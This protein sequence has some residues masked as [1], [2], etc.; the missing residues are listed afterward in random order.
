VRDCVT[1][2]SHSDFCK[3]NF[4]VSSDI[5]A[6]AICTDA[7]PN[8]KVENIHDLEIRPIKHAPFDSLRISSV[9]NLEEPER[10]DDAARSKYAAHQSTKDTR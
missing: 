6:N 3:A 10:T 2:S 9:H 7:L 1:Y 5:E 8:L 4:G